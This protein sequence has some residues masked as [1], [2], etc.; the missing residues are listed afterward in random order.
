[1]IAKY[2]QTGSGIAQK[3]RS[4]TGARDLGPAQ[5]SLRGLSRYNGSV[6]FRIRQFEQADF[7]TLWRIDQSCFDPQL[8]Y[9]RPEL[10]FYIRRPGAFTLLAEADDADN[11]T[12]GNGAKIL[13]FIVAENRRKNG[14]IITIDVIAEGRR[15]G[16]GSSLLRAA[17]EKL[18]RAGTV[19]VT[20][21]T[22][23]NNLTAICFYKREGYFVE[24]TVAGYYSGLLGAFGV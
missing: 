8:A 1:M 24:K 5:T 21:E 2:C 17:E 14:H 22:P 18:T 6:R 15:S 20:L 4:L 9:S 16:I 12:A 23:V 13:G 11:K 3:R 10:A 19:T 7:E